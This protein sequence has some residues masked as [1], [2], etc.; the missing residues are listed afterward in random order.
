MDD[1]I[2]YIC[3]AAGTDIVRIYCRLE[4]KI[5][6]KYYY[7]DIDFGAQ[8]EMHQLVFLSGCIE[9]HP[10]GYKSVMTEENL[11]NS[12]LDLKVTYELESN[13]K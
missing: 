4:H 11:L 5:K 6:K 10:I 1:L 13:E 2:V 3:E 12:N 7:N 9:C 8:E